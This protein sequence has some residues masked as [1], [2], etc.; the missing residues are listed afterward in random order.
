MIQVKLL[1]SAET[2]ERGSQQRHVC[3]LGAH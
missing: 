1:M 3:R 2:F